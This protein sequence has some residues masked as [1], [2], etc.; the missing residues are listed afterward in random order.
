M[1][2]ERANRWVWV[3]SCSVLMLALLSCGGPV[4]L[5]RS[6]SLPSF[7]ADIQLWHGTTLTFHSRSARACGTASRC[8][9]QIKIESALSVWLI[10]EVRQHGKLETFGERLLYIPAAD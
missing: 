8:P 4:L 5:A 1:R 6:G 9:Y 3:L 2:R 10:R 7:D